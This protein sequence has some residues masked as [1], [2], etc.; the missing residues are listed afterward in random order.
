[1]K[2]FIIIYGVLVHL[3]IALLITKTD[4][5]KGLSSS[6]GYAQTNPLVSHYINNM[7][8]FQQQLNLQIPAQQNFLVGDSIAKSLAAT[9]L[10]ASV[11]NWGIGHNNT[12]LLLNN[13]DNL[14]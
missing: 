13:L 6:L 3:F 7:Y 14:I 4:F 9:N 12:E 1:M 11:I 8:K 10:N 2:K 5:F